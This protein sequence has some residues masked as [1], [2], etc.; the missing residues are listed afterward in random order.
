MAN[1]KISLNPPIKRDFV[2]NI[3]TNQQKT[4]CNQIILFQLHVKLHPLHS[5]RL[6]K[7]YDTMFNLIYDTFKNSLPNI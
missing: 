3:V 1:V 5:Y 2:E 6:H 7:C 4:L